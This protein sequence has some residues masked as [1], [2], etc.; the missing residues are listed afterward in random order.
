MKRA[1]LLVA[2]LLVSIALTAGTARAETT[3]T[4]AGT[5]TGV[6]GLPFPG[7]TVTIRNTT[8]DDT[9]IVTTDASGH[10]SHTTAVGNYSVSATYSAYRANTTYAGIDR[11]RSD[12]NFQMYEVL[13]TVTGQVTDGNTTLAGVTVTLT[14]AN[15][16]F[17]AVSTAPLGA[18]RIDNVTPGTYMAYAS[19]DGYNTSYHKTVVTLTKGSVEEISFTLIETVV[20]Y[21]KL[22]GRVTFNGDPLSGVKVILTPEEGADLVT[23]TDAS[24]NYSFDRVPPGD[25]IIYLSKDG[26]VTSEKRVTM[27]PLEGWVQDFTM[28]R[29]TLPGNS[30][31]ILN[32][33][34]SHSLMILGLGLALMVTLASLLVRHRIKTDPDLMEKEEEA[35]PSKE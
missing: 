29:N 19:K 34:L 33:D 30:G 16:S 8:T 3:I 14:G 2:F 15:A 23:V 1:A 31:F 26:Y 21:A 17:S 32:Y 7:V 11:S 20:K 24:G 25:Y 12:V 5:V 28:K 35:A 10:Y 4:I 18:Y 6:N 13:G 27:E 22:S 9:H